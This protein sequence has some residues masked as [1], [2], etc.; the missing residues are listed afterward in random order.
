MIRAANVFHLLWSDAAAQSPEV[1]KEWLLALQTSRDVRFIRPWYWQQ[2]L[3]PPPDELRARKIS[4]RYEHLRRS[5]FRPS[6]WR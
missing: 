6:T 3:A 1:R 2:P 4:F 5:L